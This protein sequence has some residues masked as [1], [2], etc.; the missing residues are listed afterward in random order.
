MHNYELEVLQSHMT[1]SR[2]HGE[3][4]SP[5]HT[6]N[7]LRKHIVRGHWGRC[8]GVQREHLLGISVRI[9]SVY[10]QSLKNT[11]FL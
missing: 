4:H 10:V 5:L 2:I 1:C 3:E 8:P 9:V 6:G 7:E 11:I